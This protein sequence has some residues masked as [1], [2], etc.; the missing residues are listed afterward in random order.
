MCRANRKVFMQD[1]QFTYALMAG[2]QVGRRIGGRIFSNSIA[3]GALFSVLVFREPN[4]FLCHTD[5]TG[6][7]KCAISSIERC[8]VY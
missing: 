1:F 7:H 5:E 4:C 8:N 2:Y 6:R 3:W